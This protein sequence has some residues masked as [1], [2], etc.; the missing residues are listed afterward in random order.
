MKFSKTILA[1]ALIVISGASFA[2]KSEF[3]DM[4]A[5]GLAMGKEVPLQLDLGR[6]AHWVGN[7][8]QPTEK[9]RS[10]IK[11]ARNAVTAPVAVAA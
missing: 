1:A 7:G 3:G 10:L 9:V 8:A 6:V 4:C 5:T 11:R 2:A